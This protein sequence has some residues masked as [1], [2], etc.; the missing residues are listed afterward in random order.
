MDATAILRS[1]LPSRSPSQFVFSLTRPLAARLTFSPHRRHH[2]F[3]VRAD[4]GAESSGSDAPTTQ[5]PP[6]ITPPDTVEVRF[7]RGSRRRRRQQVAEDGRPVKAQMREEPAAPKKW[8][9]MSPREKA[10]ELYVGEKGLLFWLNKFAY[11]SIFIMIGAWIVFRF[12]GPAL[13]F[14]QLDSPP[15]SPTSVFKG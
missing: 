1:S 3:R 4:D 15:L 10:T 9:E 7:R 2:P 11:A 14:Y 6:P 13:N 5:V 8:E 12:V